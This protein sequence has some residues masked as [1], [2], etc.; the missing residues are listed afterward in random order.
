[1]IAHL[2]GKILS[3]T[4]TLSVLDCQGVG[5]EVLHTPFTAES[6]NEAQGKLHIYM[7]VREDVIQLF[8][9]STLAEKLLFIELIKINGVGPKL[10]LGILSG[11]PL[12]ELKRAI[13]EKNI[14]RLQK[15]PGVGKKT[16]E[17][18]CIDL[19]D[20]LKTQFTQSDSLPTSA[21]LSTRDGDLESVLT[22]LGYQSNEIR[23]TVQK[24]TENRK[25][26]AEQPLEIWVKE[27]LAELNQ[28]TT[29]GAS[30][31]L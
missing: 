30:Y 26:L 3:K 7:N 1:M 16:A 11:I 24:M 4:P 6:L 20:K 22:N 10:A 25:E 12:R 14:A 2:S 23:K 29:K 17:R 31:H 18:I 9:F 19:C 15:I 27:A 13:A 5:Y 21:S 28:T 8:G